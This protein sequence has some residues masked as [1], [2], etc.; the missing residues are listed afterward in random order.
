MNPIIPKQQ[1]KNTVTMLGMCLLI[2]VLATSGCSKQTAPVSQSSLPYPTESESTF[3]DFANHLESV[4]QILKIPG[5][6]AA[7][8][9]NQELVWAEGFGYSDLENQVK[10]T[11]DTPYGLASV[12]KPVAAVVIMQLVE[13]GLIGLDDPIADYGVTLL[14][15]EITVRHLLTHTSEG[16]PGSKHE[17]NGSRYGYLSGVIEGATG[18]T[19]AENLSER[20][21]LPQGMDNTAL[22][23]ISNWGGPSQ[24][25]LENFKL[26]LFWGEAFK[27]Y[28]DVYA[29]LTQPYQFDSDYK[30][31]PGMYHLYHNTG[32]GLISSVTDLAK[33]DIALDRDMLLGEAVKAEMFSPAYSTYENRSDLN[34]GL[35]WYVQD[36]EGLRLLW[37]SGRWPPST[38]AL[39]LKIPEKNLTFIVLANTD[40]LTVPFAGIGAGNISQSSLFQSFYRYFIF[41]KQHGYDLPRIDWSAEQPVIVQQLEAVQDKPAR[42]FLE[43]EL[44]SF[45]QAFASSGQADQADVLRQVSVNVYPG[46]ALSRDWMATQTAGQNPIIRPTLHAYTAVLLNR[47]AMIWL[48][49]VL[50]S[51]I[52]MALFLL[53]T[54]GFS[55]WGKLL[56]WLSTL[57]LGPVSLILIYLLTRASRQ[58]EQPTN[59]Q[60]AW[61]ASALCIGGYLA[62]WAGAI[63]L[64]MRLGSNPHPLAILGLTYF[65]P[66]LTGL[67]LVRIPLQ[68]RKNHPR[69]IFSRALLAEIITFNL[70]YAVF[71]PLTMLISER[72]FSTIPHP[73]NPIFWAMTA[74]IGMA[75]LVILTPLQYWMIRRGSTVPSAGAIYDP[76]Q[77]GLV[78]VRSAWPVFL[79]TF[80][81]MVAALAVTI[82]QLS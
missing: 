44:W 24:I 3:T 53:R 34:Y 67:F 38:S 13:E 32:A 15:N 61:E 10:A 66:L 1:R 46:S 71:F 45:R 69:R 42:D 26:M 40:N 75:G 64:L 73:S 31:V 47:G 2:S 76:D 29:R 19:F 60:R 20:I 63:A 36:F 18:K 68:W 22:N 72:L 62:A 23:P 25:G 82:M 21:L 80:L 39:F 7:I 65:I 78:K 8:V 6:S 5:L 16:I 27:N 9:Q 12:T 77:P 30:I 50:I 37:H 57:F 74:C 59:W 33:F 54:A 81:V 17:Y 14:G 79:T 56:W 43:R 28:P 55:R 52:W 51:A 35:G 70:S 11:P 58:K 41:P 48:T 49:L 4:R